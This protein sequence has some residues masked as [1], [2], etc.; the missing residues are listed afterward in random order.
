[1]IALWI[2]AALAA[3]RPEPRLKPLDGL[4]GCWKAPGRVRGRDATSVARGEW[5]LGGRY[6][7]LHVRS[8][9]A[10]NPYEAAILY[11]AGEKP[12]SI[13]SFWMDTLG[14]AYSTSGAGS[15]TSQGFVVEY[16]YPDSVY[17]NRFARAASGWRWTILERAA[18]KPESVFA[19]YKL[20]PA[21]CRGMNFDF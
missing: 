8:M 14:G 10:S 11:G 5:H 2:A 20:S 7:I 1:M 18:G 13:T 15:V 3:Q 6:F 16:R 9:A 21:S 17:A 12:E 19:E 4:A